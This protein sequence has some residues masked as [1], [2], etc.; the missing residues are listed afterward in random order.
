MHGRPNVN[1]AQALEITDLGAR[2][3]GVTLAEGERHFVAF[4]LPGE[5]V[6]PKAEGLP[7][8]LSDPSPD[9]RPPVCRHFGTCGGCA[10]QHMSDALYARWKRGNVVAAFNQRGLAPEIAPLVPVP[11][12]SRRRAVLTARR[13]QGRVT[14]GFHRHGSHNLVDIA[15]CPV[16][17]PAIV[18]G[19]PALRAIS[20]ALPAV[21]LRLTVLAA[22]TYLDVAIE[23]VRTRIVGATAT[24]LARIASANGI[25]R[26]TI[27]GE[28]MIER[29]PVTLPIG[30]LETVVP[31]GI[32]VQAV[33]EAEAELVLRVATATHGARRIAD[34]FCGSG[35]FALTLAKGARIAAIDSD[36]RAIA[37]LNAAV[38]SR[39]GIKPIEATVRDLF[40]EPLSCKELD[41]LDAVVF[42]PQRAGA[43]KQAEQLARSKVATIV[44]VSCD[45]GTLARDVRILVDGGYAIESVT[46]IDQFLYSAHVEIV[47]VLR[48]LR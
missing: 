9:R 4:A 23:G 34:L 35:T 8:I 22:R 31:P 12:G 24:E 14:L 3:D 10:A 25:A 15:E 37:A 29:A 42:D 6:R 44:A 46:P 26:L 11:P 18:N 30:G 41:G 21:D 33:E 43:M 2:G 39:Q 47:A 17:R 5:R 7:D 40:R 45:A 36:A 48:R 27:A 20:A 16:M 13:V 38:R 32:F 1:R 19:L 28:A